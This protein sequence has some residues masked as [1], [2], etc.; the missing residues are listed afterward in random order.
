M[1]KLYQIIVDVND[2]FSIDT[3]FVKKV[4]STILKGV[5]HHK[6]VAVVEKDIIDSIINLAIKSGMIIKFTYLNKSEFDKAINVFKTKSYYNQIDIQYHP[7]LSAGKD[8]LI[9]IRNNRNEMGAIRISRM[10]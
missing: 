1:K 10:I 2:I 3:T 5:R 4:T 6:N 9:S 7:T 8:M